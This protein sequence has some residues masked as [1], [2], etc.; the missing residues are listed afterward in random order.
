MDYHAITSEER[1]ILDCICRKDI[2]LDDY[3]NLDWQAFED[4]VAMHRLQA[5]IYESLKH[6]QD[7][8]IRDRVLRWR[9]FLR[10]RVD[11]MIKEFIQIGKLLD[12]E[13]IDFCLVKGFIESLQI[14]GHPYGR[15]FGD[16]DIVIF[17]DT[18]LLQ[19]VELLSQVGYIPYFPDDSV[20]EYVP[21]KVLEKS[22]STL[23]HEILVRNEAKRISVEIKV[24]TSA[25][26]LEQF[27]M[28]IPQMVEY[29]YRDYTFKTFDSDHMFL[30]LMANAYINSEV[31]FNSI[32]ENIIL[33]DYYDVYSY[34]CTHDIK[35]PALFALAKE[36]DLEYPVKRSFN[37]LKEIVELD[38][39][40]LSFIEAN[41]LS[42]QSWTYMRIY[43]FLKS[44][45]WKFPF[46]ERAFHQSRHKDDYHDN[47]KVRWFNMENLEEDNILYLNDPAAADCQ[48]SKW[49][50]FDVNSGKEF[51]YTFFI[52]QNGALEILIKAKKK[53]LA[54]HHFKFRY[55]F[56]NESI[57][58][59]DS[60][61]HFFFDLQEAERDGDFY[62]CI[63]PN[64]LMSQKSRVLYYRLDLMRNS[65][66]SQN[67]YI[68]GILLGFSEGVMS[69]K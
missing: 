55:L 40:D 28:Y 11:A 64:I 29:T 5:C 59:L 13:G 38:H 15:S 27:K 30:H 12:K 68:N 69:C 2:I 45:N 63:V 18:K 65:L 58:F 49:L 41:C 32:T 61:E 39:V 67:K 42:D 1:L 21:Q 7:F 25:V 47:F 34:I 9:F 16:L 44:V 54:G 62:K 51:D 23:Y 43:T 53:E 33:R 26:N 36:Y 52:N 3:P 35:W 6:I 50:P 37:N 24:S 46:I 17:D 22:I 8:P 4:K 60:L 57:N 10:V 66:N 19:T 31:Y 56:D 20:G 14:Y 48:L